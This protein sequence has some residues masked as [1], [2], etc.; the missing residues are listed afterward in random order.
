MHIHLW[1][2]LHEGFLFMV[3]PQLLRGFGLLR[4]VGLL[5][6][7]DQLRMVFSNDG[8]MRLFTRRL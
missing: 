2:K 1:V 4:E 5:S 3:V 7:F 6:F 8:D